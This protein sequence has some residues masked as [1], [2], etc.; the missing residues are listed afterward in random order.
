VGGVLHGDFYFL[1]LENLTGKTLFDW[2][3]MPIV[4]CLQAGHRRRFQNAGYSCDFALTQA[5]D[6]WWQ[7][8][9]RSHWDFG[10][11]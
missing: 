3:L 6:D 10:R 8:S 7:G 2:L 5:F 4:I 11:E 1:L 9:G